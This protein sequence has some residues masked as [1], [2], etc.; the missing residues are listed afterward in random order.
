M[1][2]QHLTPKLFHEVVQAFRAAVATTQGDQE[3]VE[4]CRFQVTDSTGE[5][6]LQGGSGWLTCSPVSD[7][8]VPSSQCSMLW[9]PSA[10]EISL[11]TY[12]SCCLERPQRIPAGERNRV[13]RALLCKRGHCPQDLGPPRTE[14]WQTLGAPE[15]E[16]QKP[17]GD[18]LLPVGVAPL[19]AFFFQKR[20]SMLR[21][22]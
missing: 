15:K 5:Q 17:L 14:A 6:G 1:L 4:A 9:S 18:V 8:C 3:G 22:S 7:I 10:S 12:I 19:L 11:D 16:E 13:I 20:K 2:L 21:I